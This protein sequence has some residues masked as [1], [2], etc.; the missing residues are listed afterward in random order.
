MKKFIIFAMAVMFVVP[1]FA[2]DVTTVGDVDIELTGSMRVRWNYYNNIYDFN[3]HSSNDMDSDFWEDGW[4]P[5]TYCDDDFAYI[6]FRFD[7]VAKVMLTRNVDVVADFQFVDFFGNGS[8]TLGFRQGGFYGYD[9][10]I[11]TDGFYS[12]WF[13]GQA[14]W[15]DSGEGGFGNPA[16]NPWAGSAPFTAFDMGGFG[17]NPAGAGQSK[18]SG[19]LGL[20]EAYIHM[21]NVGDSNW[22]IKL[23]R[24]KMEFGTGL[25]IADDDW[26]DGLA[27]DGVRTD[28][29]N[30]MVDLSMFWMKLHEGF[31]SGGI[32][33]EDDGDLWGI[34]STWSP[35]DKVNLDGYLLYMLSSHS[36]STNMETITPGFRFFTVE[37]LGGGWNFNVEFAY[38]QN[39]WQNVAFDDNGNPTDLDGTGFMLDSHVSYTFDSDYEPTLGFGFTYISGDD[40]ISDG[41]DDTDTDNDGFWRMFG[42]SHG[43]WG[44]A[45]MLYSSLMGSGNYDV[46]SPMWG[47]SG[48]GGGY[49]KTASPGGMIMQVNY[50]MGTG[51]DSIRWG[52]N[53]VWFWAA[54]DSYKTVDF[55]ANSGQ[56]TIKL[57]DFMGWEFDLWM[58][59][60][61]SEHY[62][63]NF[64][65]SYFNVGDFFQDDF[66][67]WNPSEYEFDGSGNFEGF[68][69]DHGYMQDNAWSAYANFV[70]TW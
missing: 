29:S 48:F 28:W 30:D 49:V 27:F 37:E 41:A 8:S 14:Q 24:Q 42:E 3:D 15:D 36:A 47:F 57:D 19:S 44:N 9:S 66:S 40:D 34:Y 67:A 11:Y 46:T 68:S 35:W 31:S 64:N 6:P 65:L 2:G 4:C 70:A 7:L 5:S 50:D 38:Q 18:A 1:V 56:E 25:L 52:A 60:E 58:S 26:Y 32:S 59:Y 45:D 55:D 17:Y 62:A 22:N 53:T 12:N 16:D 43:R 61:Y 21:R 13:W 20:F 23:G 54:E 63:M 33:D 39:T 69:N 10:F 51:W